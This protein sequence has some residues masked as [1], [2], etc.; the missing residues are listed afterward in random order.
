MVDVNVGD[1][2]RLVN[3]NGDIAEVTV[4]D[5]CD[6]SLATET[7][8]FEF[9][10]GWSVTEVLPKPAPAEPTKLYAVVKYQN[11]PGTEF[12]AV[13]CDTGAWLDEKTHASLVWREIVEQAAP[14]SVDI[15]FPG[16]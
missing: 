8:I 2:V 5:V 10:D 6:Q 12:V 15:V 1:R 16:V 7:N 13:L 9:D 11:H 4:A 3:T 14:G